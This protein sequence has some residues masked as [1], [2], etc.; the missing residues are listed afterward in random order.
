MLGGAG[1]IGAHLCAHLVA[2]GRPVV[3][4]DAGRHFGDAPPA[5]VAAAARWRR[6]ELLLGVK[7][8]DA[9]VLDTGTLEGLVTEHRPAAVVHL[10]NL[11]LAW[12]A[13]HDP[14]LGR[15]AILD[16]TTSVLRALDS[17]PARLVYVSSSMVYGPFAHEPMREAGPLRPVGAYGR[18]KRAAEDAVRSARADAVVVRPSAV[19]GPG[20]PN[21]RIVHKLLDAAHAGTPLAVDDPATALDF[22]WVGD[23]ADGLVLAATVP[24]A[25][26]G[27]FNLTRGVARTL[28]EAAELLGV[29]LTRA[30]EA[31][32]RPR[33]GAL[34]ISS[35]RA[36]LGF[37][38][39][40]DLED[41]LPL[42]AGAV[43]SAV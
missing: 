13:D 4:V 11:P 20:D 8:V 23:L 21:R 17:S 22:T 2:A 3:A 38:P 9:D 29:E 33:R 7:V 19:Y 26:G 30:P 31:T 36:L 41:G 16:A 25:A 18:A 15:R 42:L 1:F 34:D 24:G 5:T 37:A 35:A 28:R 43:E 12:V 40:A 14:A 27:T 10:A 6:R 39:R 32:P